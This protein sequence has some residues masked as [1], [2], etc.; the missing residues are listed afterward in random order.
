MIRKVRKILILSILTICLA[1]IEHINCEK[2]HTIYTPT[3][4]N[5]SS[6]PSCSHKPIIRSGARYYS[7]DLVVKS[8]TGKS[9]AIELKL[10]TQW[11]KNWEKKYKRPADFRSEPEQISADGSNFDDKK[12]LSAG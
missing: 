11:K 5:N 3:K 1:D 12:S 4:N 7:P 8:K 10:A 9:L 2:C 6:C